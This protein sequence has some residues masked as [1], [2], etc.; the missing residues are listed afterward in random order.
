L[1]FYETSI[2]SLLFDS[3]EFYEAYIRQLKRMTNDNYIPNLF[4]S[5]DKELDINLAILYK[6]YPYFDYFRKDY[7][8]A[9]INYVKKQLLEPNLVKASFVNFNKTGKIDID[10]DNL[11]D[12]SIQ[13]L[14]LEMDGELI[15]EPKINTIVKSTITDDQYFLR[16]YINKNQKLKKVF[17]NEL[18]LLYKVYGLEDIYKV[19]IT[20]V[21]DDYYKS[22]NIINDEFSH[23]FTYKKS[24]I[25]QFPFLEINNTKREIN[26]LSGHYIIDKDLIVPKD[27]KFIINYGVELDLVD[28]ANIL[29]YS[30]IYFFGTKD[31]PITVHSSDSS[32]QGIIILKASQE[33]SLNHVYFDNLSSPSKN[34]WRLTGSVT[35]YNSDVTIFNCVFSNNFS[36]D[37]LNV[38][39]SQFDIKYTTFINN[40]SDAIDSDYSDGYIVNSTFTNCGNDGL[41]I[42][43]SKV[44]VNN[45]IISHAG[46]KGISV[47]ENSSLD[48]NN[49]EINNSEV[50]IASK[51]LSNVNLSGVKIYGSTIGFTVFQK[52]PEF[53]PASIIVAD[54]KM[55]EVEVPYLN[56]KGSTIITDGKKIEQTDEKV[57]EILY[58]VLY[59]KSSK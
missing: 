31:K 36:E 48:G 17:N 24:N 44:N 21:P 27:Y 53:G 2:L 40:Q 5:I 38:I 6:E 55:N 3:T 9:N 50:G 45:I 16:F 22:I 14:G 15:Y 18:F 25:D 28:S 59:G 58:G 47:G 19:K 10:I 7:Y 4:S 32:G 11:K 35:F 26:V 42:S 13:I 57:R 49:I 46:D 1:I 37:A 52:K 8:T 23:Y 34:G 12:I 43:G 30:P 39:R 20:N 51:D 41:D 33:S 56:E 29:S 54:L